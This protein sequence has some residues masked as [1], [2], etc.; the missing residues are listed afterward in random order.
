MYVNKIESLAHEYTYI[1]RKV[2]SEEDI[3]IFPKLEK[4]DDEIEKYI[5]DYKAF[6]IINS[7]ANNVRKYYILIQGATMMQDIIFKDI[8]EIFGEQVKLKE[9]ISFI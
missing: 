1:I 5:E 7:N 8:K 6:H 2:E 4:L 9:T 3:D